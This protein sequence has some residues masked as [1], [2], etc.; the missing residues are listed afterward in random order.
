MGMTPWEGRMAIHIGRRDF[1]VTALAIW[2][3]DE[4]ADSAAIECHRFS[5]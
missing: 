3:T 4:E 5:G 1:A 2:M